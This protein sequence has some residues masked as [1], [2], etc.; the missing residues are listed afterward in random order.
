MDLFSLCFDIGLKFKSELGFLSILRVKYISEEHFNMI[1]NFIGTPCL[2]TDCEMCEYEYSL[3]IHI[4][5]NN[6]KMGKQKIRIG[7]NNTN[8]INI[9]CSHLHSKCLHNAIK[10]NNFILS[11][12]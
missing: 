3:F 8:V 2:Y 1:F 5:Y 12:K 9:L 4:H 6:R 10:I 7:Q 11:Y